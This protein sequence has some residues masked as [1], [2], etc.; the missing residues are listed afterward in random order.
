MWNVTNFKPTL[1]SSTVQV[2]FVSKAP[3]LLWKTNLQK[4]TA[5]GEPAQVTID[6][7]QTC[8]CVCVCVR[9]DLLISSVSRVWSPWA[10]KQ[11]TRTFKRSWS[12]HCLSVQNIAL[13]RCGSRG[14]RRSI[15]STA[16]TV[17]GE[18]RKRDS[19]INCIEMWGDTLF[20][21]SLLL[22]GSKWNHGW[23]FSWEKKIRVLATTIIHWEAKQAW[24]WARHSC[25]PEPCSEVRHLVAADLCGYWTVTAATLWDKHTFHTTY[26]C[27][28]MG[29]LINYIYSLTALNF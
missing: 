19:C 16:P 17:N 15:I 21:S 11:Q 23:L 7:V 20:V 22:L 14:L 25:F 27:V 4:S 26:Y 18:S 10:R 1:C 29:V 13:S 2:R 8:V 3:L 24:P 28:V 9:Y 12:H 5:N 6:T